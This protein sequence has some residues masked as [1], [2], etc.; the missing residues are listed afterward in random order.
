VLDRAELREGDSV[1]DVGTGSGLLALGA[2][3]RVGE[4]GG[5]IALDV[6]PDCLE[7]L[8]LEAEAAGANGR[9]SFLLGSA[10][11]LP[12]PNVSV[13]A[14]LT[15]SVLIY[16]ADKAEAAREFF[17]VLR[18]G[19]RFSLFEP[20]NR[21]NRRLTEMAD[22]G[23][24]APLVSDWEERQYA[25]PDDA[26]CNF[27]EQDLERAFT[28]AGFVDLRADMG[29]AEDTMTGE[30]MLDMQGAPDRPTLRREWTEELPKQ[31]DR[32]VELLAG[33][34][35]EVRYQHLFLSGAKPA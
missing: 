1:L 2:L 5:V 11:V 12:L 14:A 19:G 27:D 25:D 6:S 13:D 17:R 26:M 30:R 20:I 10:D 32:L 18:P 28:D 35:L 33:Q 8:R 24:L 9:L 22:F 23:E 7:E 4:D 34:E 3:G 15:R 16:V 21:H 31:A 29:A